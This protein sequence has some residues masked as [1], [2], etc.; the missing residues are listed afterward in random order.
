MSAVLAALARHL[1]TILGATYAASDENIGKAVKSLV[2]Q[3]AAGDTNAIGGSIVTMIAIIW[4]I[5]DKS[6]QKVIIREAK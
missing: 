6:R 4:S 5:Y 1:L 2:E 3:I